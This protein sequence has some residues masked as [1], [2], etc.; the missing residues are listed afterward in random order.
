MDYEKQL[1]S[2]NSHFSGSQRLPCTQ[3]PGKSFKDNNRLKI[4]VF[5]SHLHPAA[6]QFCRSTYTIT[7]NIILDKYY[8]DNNLSTSST[9]SSTDSITKLLINLKLQFPTM[10]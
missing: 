8:I 5:V 4:H 2:Q 6:R 3:C 7:D 9:F 1:D 10:F